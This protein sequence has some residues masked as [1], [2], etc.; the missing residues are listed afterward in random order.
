MTQTPTLDV[1]KYKPMP[2]P[3]SKI[4]RGFIEKYYSVLHSKF[5]RLKPI[6]IQIK[7]TELLVDFN[8]LS[9]VD[10]DFVIEWGSEYIYINFR[11]SEYWF[12]ITTKKKLDVGYKCE[13]CGS[14]KHL[15][16]H[17][18]EYVFRGNEHNNLDKLVVV[19]DDCHKKL[20]GIVDKVYKRKK[21]RNLL[22]YKRRRKRVQPK[23]TNDT[24]K[25]VLI[26]KLILLI[27]LD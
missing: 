10:K 27:L 21:K 8:A 20:H 24:N 7:F 13:N 25:D 3:T 17:H 5:P 4:A 26:K 18:A 12:I 9:N 2:K 14:S 1:K 23:I 6:E 16:T 11:R 15:Q 22:R 19:C